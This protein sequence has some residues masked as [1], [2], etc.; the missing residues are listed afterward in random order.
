MTTARMDRGDC[1]V[2]LENRQMMKYG[3]HVRTMLNVEAIVRKANL[4]F[5]RKL[6]P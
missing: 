1:H 6:N 3:R 2:P 5:V 4:S